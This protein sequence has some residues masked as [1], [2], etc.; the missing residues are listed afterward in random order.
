MLDEA[1][2]SA[3]LT[4]RANGHG[5]RKIAQSLGVA[6]STVRRVRCPISAVRPRLS[7]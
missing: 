6:R 2:R 7:F 4:L 1:T 3:I 5:S